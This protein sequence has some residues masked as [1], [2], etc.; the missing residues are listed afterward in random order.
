MLTDQNDRVMFNTKQF[1]DN[2]LVLKTELRTFKHPKFVIYC[3]QEWRI[4][5]NSHPQTATICM[6]FCGVTLFT[7]TFFLFFF[8][9]LICA[10]I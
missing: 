10:T 7:Y 1:K 8:F 5:A 9:D 4:N 2:V 3:V 6:K